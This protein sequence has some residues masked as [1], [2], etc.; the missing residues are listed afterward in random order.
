MITISDAEVL[1]LF[2]WRDK[3]GKR[4][5]PDEDGQNILEL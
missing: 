2:G 4:I 1:F 5:N 3:D